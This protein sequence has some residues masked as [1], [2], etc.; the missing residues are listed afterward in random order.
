[1]EFFQSLGARIHDAWR[2]ADFDE[3]VFHDVAVAAL[4]A[5]PP[6]DHVSTDDVLD[7]VLGSTQLPQQFDIA[8]KFGQPPITV[9]RSDRFHI[10]VNFWVDGTTSVHQHGFSGAFQVLGGS[11]LHSE[12]EFKTAR[13][14]CD[15]L[16]IGDL[17]LRTLEWLKPGHVRPIRAGRG[18]IHSLFHLERP[19]AS[20]VVR[21]AVDAF[22]GPQ[23]DYQRHGIAID[24]FHSND[25]VARQT[26]VLELLH[27]LERPDFLPRARRA[28]ESADAY[29]TAMLLSKVAQ[30]LPHA[31][32]SAF[33]DEIQ[34]PHTE[35]M[36]RLRR[37]RDEI[38][39]ERA[40]SGR[41]SRIQSPECRFFLAMLL[42]VPSR[43]RI[44]SLVRE[45]YPSA[46]PEE[47]VLRWIR[48]L[49]ATRLDD[50]KSA[51]DVSFDEAGL[52]IVRHLVEGA[53]DEQVVGRLRE[54]YDDVD[55]QRD[56]VLSMCGALRRSYFFRYLMSA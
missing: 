10:D 48:E 12:Y 41:R 25:T 11:S 37:Q 33:I 17:E 26:Q 34:S 50:G 28:V 9:H 6:H 22:A 56:N 4:E 1:V 20:V 15:R 3:Q 46:R 36:A 42:N 43:E 27:T 35:L 31:E 53:S 38:A 7:W 51:I 5:A 16:L 45:A 23:Y 30:L 54:S 52:E 32:Y 47:T 18:F 19:S 2:R 24:P 8:A 21:T 39:R 29:A 49:A 40:I 44:L 55:G 14:Y 13:R